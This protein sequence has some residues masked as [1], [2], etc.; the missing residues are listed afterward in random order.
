MHKQD[1]K[2]FKVR[3]KAKFDLN[4]RV[5]ISQTTKAKVSKFCAVLYLKLNNIFP[6]SGV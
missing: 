3:K 1:F 5:D 4:S 6:K 2:M